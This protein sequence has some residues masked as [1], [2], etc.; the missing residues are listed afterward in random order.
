MPE[1]LTEW[2]VLPHERLAR[3]DSDLLTV[4]GDV[5]M[6]LAHFP[7]RMTVVRLSDA[8]LVIYSAIAL[9]EPE[10]EAIEAFGEPAY[11][12]VPSDTHR[13]DA[14]IWKTR[15]PALVVIAPE[16]A[17]AKVEEVVPVDATTVT[18]GDSRV[19]FV[20]V[21]GTDGHEAA[22]LVASATGSTLIVNDF[23]GN[24]ENRP[25]FG[26]ILLRL[27]GFTGHEPRIP[28][29]AELAL[30]KDKDAL[31]A[32]LRAWSEVPDL[33]RIVVSHGE[34]IEDGAAAILQ[35]LAAS[36]TGS[37]PGK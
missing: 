6:P 8:K 7:R 37:A 23:I 1:P 25:G 33:K 4:R 2:S 21:P 26:G 32:Q 17:R 35:G 10:M 13:L 9:D 30:I 24:V 11:L 14:A 15:Y 5:Q 36:L 18:F 27:M 3:L 29:Y 19:Q 28:T 16:G 22:L 12:I 20:T 31:A 34:P